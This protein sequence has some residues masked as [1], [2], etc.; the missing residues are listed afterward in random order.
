[1]GARAI[2]D[3][4]SNRGYDLGERAVRYNLKILDELGFT[5]KKGYSG[6]VLTPLGS[7]ELGDALVDDRIGFVNTRIEEYMFKTSFDPNDR[8]RRCNRQ[9]QHH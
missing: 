7:R 9:Y 1:M 3:C 4:L 5:K 6:R 2:S 8:S